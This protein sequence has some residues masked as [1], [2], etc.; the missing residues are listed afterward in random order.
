MGKE[1]A[2]SDSPEPRQSAS[3]SGWDSADEA[4]WESFPA[5]DP[6]AVGSV[7]GLEPPPGVEAETAETE[8]EGGEEDD[9][10]GED[11]DDERDDEPAPE[12]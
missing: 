9:D 6:P 7:F 3:T 10:G 5:S 11:H 4:S 8:A 2:V 12:T 1:R